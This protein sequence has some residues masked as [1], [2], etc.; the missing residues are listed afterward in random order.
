MLRMKPAVDAGAKERPR[1]KPAGE[2][3]TRQ[4]GSPLTDEV[5]SFMEPRFG[6]DFG[7]VSIHTDTR[8]DLLSASVNAR[9]FTLGPH[10]YFRAGAYDP[11][12]PAGRELIAHELTHVMQQDGSA[13]G[14]A[15]M[16]YRP[17]IHHAA[18]APPTIR[19]KFGM[20]LELEVLVSEKIGEE[21]VP[22]SYA[23][24][25]LDKTAKIYD[26][27][28]AGLHL[29]VDHSNVLLSRA[30]E[31][32]SGVSFEEHLPLTP[33]EEGSGFKSR[34]GNVPSTSTGR[35]FNVRGEQTPRT[36]E[37]RKRQGYASIIEMVTRP[38]DEFKE[39]WDSAKR[40]IERAVELADYIG[41]RTEGLRKRVPLGEV[42]PNPLVSNL[43][44][45]INDPG[46]HAQSLR[47]DIQL[48]MGVALGGV[49]KLFD[50]EVAQSAIRVS[51]S[52]TKARQVVN[53]LMP[54]I[55][56]DF[57]NLKTLNEV[58]LRR[59][60]FAR[61]EGLLILAGTYLASGSE[62][63]AQALDKNVVPILI[64]HDLSEVFST[65]NPAELG[66]LNAA[67]NKVNG[68]Y[69]TFI[70]NHLMQKLG[71]NGTERVF[72]NKELMSYPG[73]ISQAGAQ[74]TCGVWLNNV[75][76]GQADNLHQWFEEMR[77]IHAEGVGEKTSGVRR[78]KGAVMETRGT[79][80]MA[81][82]LPERWVPL[83]KETYD[84]LRK[85]NQQS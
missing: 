18:A 30:G 8:A 2:S 81:N 77:G 74:P 67:G 79:N 68:P 82:Q 17:A 42:V 70:V 60:E 46:S 85:I 80:T 11:G 35:D 28:A 48:T 4:A 37:V 32:Q 39:D 34:I 13:A 14:R 64:R 24:P 63:N 33:Q 3:L 9:A 49:P 78:P 22:E 55:I 72:K 73:P 56:L 21:D 61:L 58:A 5:R 6:A 71:R 25:G 19:R 84:A 23:D 47:A 40:P 7:G 43:Y 83:F 26:D 41:S 54:L 57:L 66:L 51:E 62:Q 31:H 20:E 52:M 38:V 44:L 10:I 16:D 27:T 15:A 12:T 50:K 29:V 76:T 69:L 65:L 1:F 75:L 45:G 53:Q 36:T 59:R